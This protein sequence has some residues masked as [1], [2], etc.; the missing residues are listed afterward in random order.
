MKPLT[1]H[2][3][4]FNDDNTNST[5]GPSSSPSVASPVVTEQYAP[6]LQAPQLS[7][8]NDYPGRRQNNQ[9]YPRLSSVTDYGERSMSIEIDDDDTQQMQL[10]SDFS[11]EPPTDPVFFSDT[12][13]E[14]GV[15]AKY[16]IPSDDDDT[17]EDDDDGEMEVTEAIALNIN[18]KHSISVAKQNE[19]ARRT[20]FVPKRRSSVKFAGEIEEDP[21]EEE[22]E[23]SRR[24]RRASKKRTSSAPKDFTIALG[25]PL[26]EPEPP[27]DAWLALAAMASS[28]AK[29]DGTEGGAENEEMELDNALTRLRNARASFDLRDD[30]R[31]DSP[32][33]G[34]PAEELSF[35]E[36]SFDDSMDMGDRTLNVTNLMGRVSTLEIAGDDT[37]SN[38]GSVGDDD[39]AQPIPHGSL[40]ETAP[41]NI[42]RKSQSGSIQE[43]QPTTS[44]FGPSGVDVSEPLSTERE[45]EPANVDANQDEGETA[46]ETPQQ[47]PF[48][49]RVFSAPTSAP[50]SR[51]PVLSPSK[52][53]TPSRVTPS[54]KR[55][56]PAF[57]VYVD[58]RTS[59]AKK[60]HIDDESSVAPL[61]QSQR[62]NKPSVLTDLTSRPT[63]KPTEST[64]SVAPALR[65]SLGGGARR[66]SGFSFRRQSLASGTTQQ[67]SEPPPPSDQQGNSLERRHP[68]EQLGTSLSAQRKDKDPVHDENTP[69]MPRPESRVTF[70]KLPTSESAASA[71]V[72]SGIITDDTPAEKEP[73]SI[74]DMDVDHDQP[75][76]PRLSTVLETQ[77]FEEND[78]EED[79]VSE[80]NRPIVL[81]A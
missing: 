69:I 62:I 46:N 22:D 38:P 67:S 35:T 51:I 6:P 30:T 57:S 28:V 39:F 19:I 7:N 37:E 23:E 13:N 42:T 65:T 70:E 48:R 58:P 68:Q 36:S 79:L 26:K 24:S 52:S 59:P 54:K 76:R 43:A 4:I 12:P 17:N 5:S 32:L 25:Q 72:P 21:E 14:G 8:E 61:S 45:D 75:L 77:S 20:S 44:T 9:P 60:R 27:S 15:V 71:E 66:F 74:M 18:R 33:S 80:I 55:P 63:D 2:N 73:M 53:G 78:F 31:E 16:G 10:D 49:P 41:L 29:K 50:P 64:P 11:S 81:F 56:A 1:L 34:E 40:G 3:R 47:Q